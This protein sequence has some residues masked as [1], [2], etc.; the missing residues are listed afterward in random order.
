MPTIRELETGLAIDENALDQELIRRPELFYAAAVGL[1][2]ANLERDKIKVDLELVYAE[3]DVQFR[4]SAEDAGEKIT[5]A[6]LSQQ[7]TNTPRM[8]EL[9]K[10][11]ATVKYEAERWQAIKEGFQQKGYDLKTLAD[12]Y[13]AN[14]FSAE[15]GGRDRTN[16]KDQVATHVRES[17]GRMRREKRIRDVD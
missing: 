5:E 6:R 11:Y 15:S 8:R 17:A 12:L 3:L 9:K 16:A 4:A 2:E 10:Q 1:A 7:I 13:T 14:Y